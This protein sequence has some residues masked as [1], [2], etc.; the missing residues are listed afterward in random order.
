[1][2]E[3]KNM[4]KKKQYYRFLTNVLWKKELVKDH[5]LHLTTLKGQRTFLQRTGLRQQRQL[6]QLEV[7]MVKFISYK[8]QKW[9]RI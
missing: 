2:T 8:C 7:A 4:L 6:K 1:M 3:V 5:L 9:K